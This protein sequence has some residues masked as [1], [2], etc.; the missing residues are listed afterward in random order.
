MRETLIW[1]CHGRS[2]RRQNTLRA[3]SIKNNH[4]SRS[5]SRNLSLDMVPNQR[6][7]TPGTSHLHPPQALLAPS[8]L[9]TVRYRRTWMTST[10]ITPSH[11]DP[12]LLE[13]TVTA[14]VKHPV[15]V[16]MEASC[17]PSHLFPHPP[18]LH[19]E[20][21]KDL[22]CKTRTRQ[23]CQEPDLE[24]RISP[25]I[26]LR[27]SRDFSWSRGQTPI[28]YEGNDTRHCT[29]DSLSR[30]SCINLAP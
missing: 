14:T 12:H 16:D 2:I 1:R 25:G 4:P 27:R 5:C 30:G 29:Q 6:R 15:P 3:P 8:L 18:T 26:S 10:A 17:E 9:P 21:M 20:A 22:C 24:T 28:D 13:W 23:L 7:A 11:L 19:S